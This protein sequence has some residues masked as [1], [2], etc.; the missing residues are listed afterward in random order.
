MTRPDP[1]TS[2]FDYLRSSLFVFSAWTILSLALHL[3]WEVAQ[4]PLYT[5]WRE[6]APATIA[7]AVVHCTAGDGLIALATF[8]L[9]C[10][11]SRRVDWPWRSLSRGLPVLLVS[12]VA[13]T[14]F[15]EWRNVY[16]LG[17]WAYSEQMPMIMGIGALP[18]AQWIVVPVVA[19][20]FLRSRGGSLRS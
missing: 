6:A 2:R 10:A 7:W 16:R 13:Y 9:A 17:L 18:L 15:S 14:A 4:I 12:G 11:W 5:L 1:S 19:L 3:V 8:A 20:W